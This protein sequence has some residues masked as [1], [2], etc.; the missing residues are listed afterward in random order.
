MRLRSHRRDLLLS[1][2]SATVDRSRVPRPVGLRRL[3]WWLRT[4]A[5]LSVVGI[6]RFARAAR[7]R[8]QPILVVTGAVV[9]VIGL[10]LRSSVAA[11]SGLLVIGAFAW[12]T[13]LQNP[14]A[15]MVH[16][17]IWLRKSRDD[18]P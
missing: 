9:L 16:T 18:N 17:W 3:R 1:S 2:L 7:T 6:R 11:I 4:G 13:G 12:D 8:R 10:M 5:V 15:A 14:E